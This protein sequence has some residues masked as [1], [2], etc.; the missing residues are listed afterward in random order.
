MNY[1]TPEF[2]QGLIDFNVENRKSFK[3]AIHSMSI[4]SYLKELGTVSLSIGRQAGHTNVICKMARPWDL[5]VTESTRMADDLCTRNNSLHPN[6]QVRSISEATSDYNR[7]RVGTYRTIFVDCASYIS[8]EKLDDLY[9][10]H[11]RHHDQTF[12]LLG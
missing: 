5:I 1:L 7:G 8:K 6:V 10:M 9:Q 4:R 12:V 3:D 11:G 2:I